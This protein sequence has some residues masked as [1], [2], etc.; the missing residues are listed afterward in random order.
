MTDVHGA[1]G[2]SGEDPNDWGTDRDLWGLDMWMAGHALPVAEGPI[3]W[4]PA[5]GAEVGDRDQLAALLAALPSGASGTAS[6]EDVRVR[7]VNVAAEGEESLFIL[8]FPGDAPDEPA[9]RIFRG[10]RDSH[11]H[12]ALI[13]D[14]GYREVETVDAAGAARIIWSALETGLPVGYYSIPVADG[15]GA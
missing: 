6:R 13:D 15:L 14:R 8:E 3:T 1:G 12:E 4:S 2:G 9:L 7:A 11:Y 10:L 5:P